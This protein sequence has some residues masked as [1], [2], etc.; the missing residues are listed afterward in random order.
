VKTLIV[1]AVLGF[2]SFAMATSACPS[3]MKTVNFCKST[4]VKGDHEV[5]A[6]IFDSISICAK[7]QQ[8]FMIVD[9]NGDLSPAAKAVFESRAGGASYTMNLEGITVAISYATGTA[10]SAT[11]TAKMTMTNPNA[12]M[13]ISSTY[14]CAN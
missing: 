6:N 14:T 9:S 11:K 4:P 2:S 3:D 7:G 13:T 8:A 5:A 12:N 10:P 1:T